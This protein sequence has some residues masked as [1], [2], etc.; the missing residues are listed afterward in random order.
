MKH[1]EFKIGMEFTTTSDRVWRV[2]DIGTRTIAA[3]RI[4]QATIC[5][6][7]VIDG[8]STP[9]TQRI[10]N[11]AEAEKEG[12][13]NGPPYYGKEVVFDEYDIEGCHI[14]DP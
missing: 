12:W 10:L 13:F 14:K 11:R 2:T 5:E 8:K 4:D 9:T 1:S 7:E 3:I 6:I